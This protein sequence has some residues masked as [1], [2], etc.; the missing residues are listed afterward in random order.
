MGGLHIVGS[1][2]LLETGQFS[3]ISAEE[4]G[5]IAISFIQNGMF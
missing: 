3:V 5:I 1:L 4:C 2:L